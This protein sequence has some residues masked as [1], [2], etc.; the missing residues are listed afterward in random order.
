MRKNSN[1]FV[2][3]SIQNGTTRY[4]LVVLCTIWNDDVR[5]GGINID[6][7]KN[8][9]HFV[10]SSLISPHFSS[11]LYIA[12]SK[13]VKIASILYRDVPFCTQNAP[14]FTWTTK[15]VFRIWSQI[16]TFDTSYIYENL[17]IR[18]RK[19]YYPLFNLERLASILY[20]VGLHY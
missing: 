19:W 12:F 17:E 20:T 14:I 10:H 18:Y 6:S 16:R 3:C 4:N 13:Y 9:I 1:H 2:H 11:N 8:R 15:R 7:I 5:I